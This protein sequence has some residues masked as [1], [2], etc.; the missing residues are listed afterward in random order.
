[1]NNKV[2]DKRYSKTI[3]DIGTIFDITNSYIFVKYPKYPDTTMYKKEN[4]EKLTIPLFPGYF[5][6]ITQQKVV[7]FIAECEGMIIEQ[8]T[9]YF[10]KGYYT[11]RWTSCLCESK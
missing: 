10:P 6:N 7:L 2:G 9:G 5:K 8:G 3:K 11:K 1:M 4:F